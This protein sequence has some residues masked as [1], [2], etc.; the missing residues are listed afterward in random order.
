[1]GE[2]HRGGR[3][4]A[5]AADCAVSIIESEPDRVGRLRANAV[6]FADE[7]ARRGICVRSASAILPVV[8]GDEGKAL[9]ASAR[10]EEMGFLIPAIRYPSVALGA[11]RLR[12]TVSSEHS[13]AQISAAAEAIAGCLSG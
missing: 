10:L 4:C 12:A 9:E 5:A 8:V 6:F 13:R 7:L 11:A 3:A 2:R 1:M